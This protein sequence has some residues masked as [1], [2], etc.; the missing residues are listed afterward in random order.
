MWW[1]LLVF[2]IGNIFCLYNYVIAVQ[3]SVQLAR[4][5]ELPYGGRF[6][7]MR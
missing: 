1:E 5:E 4:I 7:K 2:F 3:L 6:W